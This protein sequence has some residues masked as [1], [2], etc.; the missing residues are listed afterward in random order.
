MQTS[1]ETREGVTPV[2]VLK[3]LR[4]VHILIECKKHHTN[5]HEQPFHG[6]SGTHTSQGRLAVRE[7]AHRRGAAPLD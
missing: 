2:V 7:L 4:K 6:Q 5:E 3:T 1:V